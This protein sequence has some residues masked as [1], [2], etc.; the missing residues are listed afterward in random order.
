MIHQQSLSSC[1]TVLEIGFLFRHVGKKVLRISRNFEDKGDSQTQEN[2]G[3]CMGNELW[4]E[5]VER[6]KRAFPLLVHSTALTT[7]SV[8]RLPLRRVPA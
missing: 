1:L 4:S 3:T 8:T 7:S 6:G 5:G 2:L